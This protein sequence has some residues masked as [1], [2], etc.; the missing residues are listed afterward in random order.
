M[1]HSV[2]TECKL[3][4]FL[5]YERGPAFGRFDVCISK[6][7]DNRQSS[8]EAKLLVAKIADSLVKKTMI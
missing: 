5:S 6:T 2:S 4:E 8:I 7:T 1:L 3:A